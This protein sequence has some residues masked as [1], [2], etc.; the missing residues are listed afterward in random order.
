[1]FVEWSFPGSS[2]A[3]E[4]KADDS[5]VEEVLENS[6]SGM[7]LNA[8]P[9]QVTLH[10]RGLLYVELCVPFEPRTRFIKDKT[11]IK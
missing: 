3:D 6:M 11:V 1:M 2:A 7:K 5:D 8:E 4:E 10:N 9:G